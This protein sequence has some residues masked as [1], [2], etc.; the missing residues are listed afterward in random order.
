[1]DNRNEY[2]DLKK[3]WEVQSP[4]V[5]I[6]EQNDFANNNSVDVSVANNNAQIQ[7]EK[8]EVESP[9]S[10]LSPEVQEFLREHPE[11]HVSG[12]GDKEKE[13]YYRAHSRPATRE[14]FEDFIDRQ[15]R[16]A[17]YGRGTA[18]H[19]IFNP[20]D[21]QKTI[22]EIFTSPIY[23]WDSNSQEAISRAWYESV[24]GIPRE[25]MRDPNMLKY[26]QAEYAKGLGILELQYSSELVVDWFSNPYNLEVAHDDI[27]ALSALGRA[28]DDYA[29][30]FA[31]DR[32]G[33]LKD[34]FD[35]GWVKYYEGGANV[36]DMVAQQIED[37]IKANPGKYDDLTNSPYDASNP[38]M[39]YIVRT[40]KPLNLAPTYRERARVLRQA[41]DNSRPEPY[42]APSRRGFFGSLYGFVGDV[43]E[44]S[45]YTLSGIPM[46]FAL[47]FAGSLLGPLGFIGGNLL[48]SYFSAADEA[49]REQAEVYHQL[50]ADGMSTQ[51]AYQKTLN[52]VFYPNMLFLTGSNYFQNMFT[53]GAPIQPIGPGKIG[54]FKGFAKTL[55]FGKDDPLKPLSWGKRFWNF[56]LSS[57]MEG[58]EEIVQG[59]I[60]N[61]ALGQ[62][63]NWS[64]LGY[65][66]L[67][68]IA[69][70]MLFDAGGHVFRNTVG[71][72]VDYV[73]DKRAVRSFIKQTK[74]MVDLVDAA[75]ASETLKRSPE[76]I[77]DF[78]EYV[79]DG[80]TKISP[81]KTLTID[82]ET[83]N[84]VLGNE[85]QEVAET[86]GVKDDFN[87]ALQGKGS[88]EFQI[89]I[90]DLVSHP[91]IFDKIKNDLQIGDTRMSYNEAQAIKN[92]FGDRLA[93][94]TEEFKQSEK[95]IT[96][97]SKELEEITQKYVDRIDK[98]VGK[99]FVESNEKITHSHARALSLVITK[100]IKNEFDARKDN[101]PELTLQKVANEN[102]WNIVW[103]SI[104]PGQNIFDES[105]IFSAIPEIKSDKEANKGFWT[106]LKDNVVLKNVNNVA[107]NS[108]VSNVENVNDVNSNVGWGLRF[109]GNNDTFADNILLDWDSEILVQPEPVRNAMNSLI[110]VLKA[111]NYDTSELERAATGKDFYETLSGMMLAQI[112]SENG[113]VHG[114]YGTVERPEKAA[115]FLLDRA[116]VPGL[117]HTDNTNA[118]NFVIWNQTAIKDL[119]V[120]DK[121]KALRL[122]GQNDVYN[123]IAHDG[124]MNPQVRANTSANVPSNGALDDFDKILGKTG[125]KNVESYRQTAYTGT[126]FD[127]VIKRFLL[128][129][130]GTGQG[131]QSFGWG[132]YSSENPDVAETY[133]TE[134]L[135]KGSD[136]VPFILKMKNGR[137]Y[138]SI[139]I[140]K[141]CDSNEVRSDVIRIDV[142]N[143][144][145][146][147]GEFISNDSADKDKRFSD[148]S[149]YNTIVDYL[150]NTA[151]I[152]RNEVVHFLDN[153]F[154]DF[155]KYYDD[156][157]VYNDYFAHGVR[158]RED[159]FKY[160][161]NFYSFERS[162]PDEKISRVRKSRDE[163]IEDCKRDGLINI[164]FNPIL[165]E[166]DYKRL[167]DLISFS[168]VGKKIDGYNVGRFRYLFGLLNDYYEAYGKLPSK[169]ELREYA[170]KNRKD[171]YFNTVT[172][173]TELF[174]I[175]DDID[176]ISSTRP[177]E[178]SIYKLKIPENEVLLDWDANIAD[179]PEKVKEVIGIITR[180]L[181]ATLGNSNEIGAKGHIYELEHA[182]TGEDFYRALQIIMQVYFIN[183]NGIIH[184]KFGRVDRGDQA[185]SLL[186]DRLGIPG[187]RYFDGYSRLKQ[188]G[189]HNF[190]IWNEDAI[191]ILGVEG[192]AFYRIVEERGFDK[193]KELEKVRKKYEGTDK[194]LKAPNGK[195][196]N[197]SEELWLLVRTPNFIRWFGDFENDSE[198]ASKVVDENGE[199]LVV[200]FGDYSGIGSRFD[201]YYSPYIDSV[202]LNIRNPYIVEL[203]TGNF[204]YRLDSITKI[205]ETW[206]NSSKYD[207]AIVD[208]VLDYGTFQEKY[209]EYLL[210]N[211]EDIKSVNNIGTFDLNNREYL[212]QE[213][214]N[215]QNDSQAEERQLITK[216]DSVFDD[217]QTIVRLFEYA[218][219]STLIHELGHI[220]FNNRRILA[221]LPD[222]A[223]YVKRD[224]ATLTK[225][226]NIEDLD[227]DLIYA[228]DE[229]V[230][231]FSPEQ[232]AKY[233]AEK[234][235]WRT[236]HEKFAAS[237]EKYC[238]E[239]SAPSNALA[240]AFR[241]FRDWLLGIYKAI[242]NVIY[243][244][245]DGQAHIFTISKEVREVMDRMLASEDEI[246]NDRTIRQGYD[247]ARSFREGVGAKIAFG[248][249][250]VDS[251][252]L[253]RY[254]YLL[255][256]E[257]DVAKLKMFQKLM[258]ERKGFQS[259][260]LPDI[261]INLSAEKD[262]AR[263]P[264]L[265]LGDSYEQAVFQGSPFQGLIDRYN[266]KFIGTGEGT[267]A[268]GWGFYFAENRATGEFY[269]KIG[270]PFSNLFDYNIAVKYKNGTV[271]DSEQVGLREL[272]DDILNKNA[273]FKFAKA[274]AKIINS[275]QEFSLDKFRNYLR[276]RISVMEDLL[277]G[278]ADL[279]QTN[280]V[281]RKIETDKKKIASAKKTLEYLETIESITRT[282]KRDEV[283]EPRDKGSVYQL[284]VPE[285][286]VLLNYDAAI[287]EQPEYV[288]ERLSEIIANLKEKGIATSGHTYVRKFGEM[289]YDLEQVKT[290]KEFYHTLEAIMDSYMMTHVVEDTKFGAVPASDMA[291]SL[292]LNEVGIPGLRFFDKGSR[293]LENREDVGTHNFVIWN[294]DVIKILGFEGDA[295][296]Y[297]NELKEP[298]HDLDLVLGESFNQTAYHGTSLDKF[299]SRFSLKFIG[300]GE[301]YQSFGWGMY[302]GERKD[303]VE[304]Y[305]T[306]GLSK[307]FDEKT[308][309][310]FS[311][312]TSYIDN[313]QYQIDGYRYI[314]DK[315]NVDFSSVSSFF[316]GMK[317]RMK[318][319]GW[320]QV[321]AEKDIINDYEKKITRFKDIVDN[322]SS[323]KFDYFVP[324][325]AE[326][327]KLLDSNV[328]TLDEV[329]KVSKF[330]TD[331]KI[332]KENP[333]RLI[334]SIY[335][336]DVPENDVLLDYDAE[337]S[338]QPEKV[339]Q[340]M[341]Q[342]VSYLKSK[343]VPTS[344]NG[345]VGSFAYSFGDK[346]HD[347]E[348]VKTGAEFYHTL[349]MIMND[350][351][352]KRK[353]S[354][355][356]YGV[357][358]KADMAASLLFDKFGIPGLR[359]FDR[360]SRVQQQGTHNFVI[361]NED[362]V[363]I[364]G[365]EGDAKRYYKEFVKEKLAARL[366][367]AKQNLAK[368][369]NSENKASGDFYFSNDK[370]GESYA[371]LQLTGTGFQGLIDRF[372]LS[373]IGSG[374]GTKW[375][376]WGLYFAENSIVGTTYRTFGLPLGKRGGVHFS[377][378]FGDGNVVEFDKYK[379]RPEL[380]LSYKD[381]AS[382]Y[383][384]AFLAR[385]YNS[386]RKITSEKLLD[387]AKVEFIKELAKFG[388]GLKKAEVENA[389]DDIA[390][391][392]KTIS[393]YQ[394]ILDFLNRPDL[395]FTINEPVDN[396]IG[397]IYYAELP[398]ND[399]L[400]DYDA[401][402]SKQP[403]KVKQAML[404]MI[405]MLHENNIDTT[406]DGTIKVHKLGYITGSLEEAKTGK[407]FYH[408][409]ET[410]MWRTINAGIEVGTTTNNVGVITKADQAAS[411]FFDNFGIPGLRFYDGGSRYRPD[412]AKYGTRNFV[413][414]NEDAIKIVDVE[415]D[416]KDI[417]SQ[418]KKTTEKAKITD[419]ESLLQ[420]NRDVQS[421]FHN[422]MLDFQKEVGGR[423]VERKGDGLKS[424][425]RITEKLAPYVAKYGSKVDYSKVEDVLAA[426]LIFDNERE[427][428]DAVEKIKLKDVVKKVRNRWDFP[429][430]G[431]YR[432]YLFHVQLS[433]GVIAELQLHHK[434]LFEVK[435]DIGHKLYEFIRS[436][437]NK[438]EMREYVD[439]VAQFSRDLY[440]AGYDGIYA[441]A[442]AISKANLSEIGDAVSKSRS[443]SES[444]T[445]VKDLSELIKK[446]LSANQRL[447]LS[448]GTSA[449][450]A[451]SPLSKYINNSNTSLKN[452]NSNLSGKAGSVN[453]S[454]SQTGY[455]LDW[456]EKL[457]EQPEE[458]KESLRKVVEF[459]INLELDSPDSRLRKS[460]FDNIFKTPEIE[461][462]LISEVLSEFGLENNPN[463]SDKERADIIKGLMDGT[464]IENNKA[465]NRAIAK[466][467]REIISSV[468]DLLKAKTG[469]E[470][471]T[472]LESLME[473]YLKYDKKYGEDITGSVA[474]S[475]LL[476]NAGI[477]GLRSFDKNNGN[478]HVY[479]ILNN[480]ALNILGNT[481]KKVNNAGTDLYNELSNV[482][483]N[484]FT[485]GSFSSESY[486][487]IVYRGAFELERKR[488]NLKFYDPKNNESSLAW[489]L[490]F[491]ESLADAEN[492]SRP[493]KAFE[494]GKHLKRGNEIILKLFSGIE[495]VKLKDGTSLNRYA[496]EREID[497]L[498]A[499][500]SKKSRVKREFAENILRVLSYHMKAGVTYDNSDLLT[501]VDKLTMPII[502][503]LWL[504]KTM[505][506]ADKLWNSG[507][508]KIEKNE[509]FNELG[510]KNIFTKFFTLY[511][512]DFSDE[513][514][515]DPFTGFIR[516]FY[517]GKAD[518]YNKKY[519]ELF[520][521]KYIKGLSEIDG[522]IAL[523]YIKERE[524]LMKQRAAILR[525][526]NLF[527]ELT[528]TPDSER[529][530][531]NVYKSNIP[532]R[533]VLLDFN[534][535]ISEQPVVVKNAINHIKRVFDYLGLTSEQLERAETGG[536]F[537]VALEN[538]MRNYI[539]DNGFFEHGRFGEITNAK[540]ATSLILDA[541]GVPGMRYLN[542][543]SATNSRNVHDFVIWNDG[544][545]ENLEVNGQFEELLKTEKEEKKFYLSD[546]WKKADASKL[547]KQVKLIDKV[548]SSGSKMPVS[549][550]NNVS[551]PVNRNTLLDEVNQ[552]NNANDFHF[553]SRLQNI[554]LKDTTNLEKLVPGKGYQ[555]VFSSVSEFNS[556]A[557][558]LAKRANVNVETVNNAFRILASRT[559]KHVRLNDDGVRYGN[560][561]NGRYTFKGVELDYFAPLWKEIVDELS[562]S[563][564]WRDKN[565]ASTESEKFLVENRKK[566]NTLSEY[567]SDC[568][569]SID[570]RKV[571]EEGLSFAEFAHGVEKPLVSRLGSWEFHR[572]LGLSGKNSLLNKYADKYN[573]ENAAYV[574]PQGKK[575]VEKI[576]RVSKLENDFKKVT[577]QLDS[578]IL[579][580]NEALTTVPLN[581]ISQSGIETETYSQTAYNV[582]NSP[583]LV[584]EYMSKT[585]NNK[586]TRRFGWGVPFSWNDNVVELR[587]KL[588]MPLYDTVSVNFG[589]GKVSTGNSVSSNEFTRTITE[590]FGDEIGEY[591]S[592]I[593]ITLANSKDLTFRKL[594]TRSIMSFLSDIMKYQ[595]ELSNKPY[596]PSARFIMNNRLEL[597]KKR[598]EFLNSVEDITLERLGTGGV[599]DISENDVLIDS[600]AKISEQPEKVQRAM[601]AIKTWL[602]DK[603]F[604]IKMLENARTG[605]EF[606]R[607]LVSI[608]NNYLVSSGR[609]VLD[610]R[611]YGEMTRPD[612]VASVL[613]DRLGVRGL[614]YADNDSEGTNN[615]V[616]WNEDEIKLLTFKGREMSGLEDIG[617]GSG[618][619]YNQ[620]SIKEDTQNFLR[621]DDKSLNAQE[622]LD[623]VRNKYFGTN[624]WLK[625]PNGQQSRLNE[626]QWL[627]VRT[628]NFKRWFGDWE[629]DPANASKA[630]D[631][632]G[633]PLVVYHARTKTQGTI[634]FFKTGKDGGRGRTTGTGAWFAE[635]RRNAEYISKE[636]LDLNRFVANTVDWAKKNLRSFTDDG[637]YSVEDILEG[638]RQGRFKGGEAEAKRIAGSFERSKKILDLQPEMIAIVKS[639]DTPEFDV[640]N[641]D[642][643]N[644]QPLDITGKQYPGY[645]RERIEE[646]KDF[647]NVSLKYDAIDR[648]NYRLY[649]VFVNARNPYIYDAH[650]NEWDN[651]AGE[652]EESKRKYKTDELVKEVRAGK[653]D[654]EN[655]QKIPYDSVIIR[656]VIDGAKIDNDKE[657][658]DDY[659]IFI[660]TNIKS[661]TRNNGEFGLGTNNI[662]KQTAYGNNN[663][664]LR[665]DVSVMFKSQKSPELSQSSKSSD[666]SLLNVREQLEA[667]HKK[668]YG[669]NQWLKAPNGKQSN[670]TE[671]QWLQVRTPNFKR[672]FGDW[673][674][675][676]K[677]ASK[678][679]DVNG[680]PLVVYHGTTVPNIKVFQRG[681]KGWLGP[682]I[683]FTPYKAYAEDYTKRGDNGLVM[684]L[685]LNIRNPVIVKTTNP[686]MELLTM[687]YGDRA[688][689]VF[690]YRY[691]KIRAREVDNF[692]RKMNAGEIKGAVDQNL[693]RVVKRYI[694]SDEELQEIFSRG[695]YDG[696]Y[697]FDPEELAELKAKP[698]YNGIDYYGTEWAVLTSKRVKSI[699]NNGFFRLKTGNIYSQTAYENSNK[700]TGKELLEQEL[701]RYFG[702][703]IMLSDSYDIGAK[704]QLEAV[705]KKYEGT[706][707]W[708]KAPNGKD[709]LL[710]RKQWLQVRTENFKKWFGDWEN[711]PEHASKALDENG[712]PLVVYHFT[713]AEGFSV[714]KTEGRGRTKGTGAFFNSNPL[715]A[716]TYARKNGTK[717]AV[718]LNIRNPYVYDA[719]RKNWNA[720]E[721]PEKTTDKFTIAVWNGKYGKGYDGVIFKNI[722]DFGGKSVSLLREVK[723]LNLG[724]DYV[725]PNSRQIKSAT[726]NNGVFGLNTDNIYRQTAYENENKK[727]RNEILEQ[728]LSKYFKRTI[729]L[730]ND[731][732]LNAQ[733]QLEAVRKK[734]EGTDQWL[735]APNGKKSNL[736]EKQWLQVRTPNFKRW[737]GDWENTP[738][739]ASKVLDENGEPLV[740]YHGTYSDE[741]DTFSYDYI[742]KGSNDYGWLGYGFYFTSKRGLTGFYGPNVMELFLNL[743][744]PFKNDAA[745][746][747]EPYKNILSMF[748][749]KKQVPLRAALGYGYSKERSMA[750]SEALQKDGYDG[751]IGD[752]VISLEYVA[753]L[754]PQ[755]KSA[756]KNNGDFSDNPN[757]FRQLGGIKAAKRQDSA[758]GVT[759]RMD[760]LEIAKRMK[761]SF[762]S[763][764]EIWIRTGW[765]CA[766]DNGWRYEIYDGQFK[767][768]GF[769]TKEQAKIVQEKKKYDKELFEF[770]N[771]PVVSSIDENSDPS[772]LFKYANEI[773]NFKYRGKRLDKKFGNLNKLYHYYKN[774]SLYVAYPELKD[775]K[776][777][778]APA[779]K[780]GFDDYTYAF[781][782]YANNAIVIR[783]DMSNEE[784][785]FALVHE[786]QHVI[787]YIEGFATGGSAEMFEEDYYNDLKAAK[788]TTA[789]LEELDK[790]IG[791]M[792]YLLDWSKFE[793]VGVKGL[794]EMIRYIDNA[795]FNSEYAEEYRQLLAEQKRLA[796]AFSDKYK[797]AEN[798]GEVYERLGGEV[799]ARNVQNRLNLS[800][801]ERRNMSP[802]KT[803]DTL[804]WINIDENGDQFS[805]RNLFGSREEMESEVTKALHSQEKINRLA[806]E[807]EILRTQITGVPRFNADEY[808]EAMAKNALPIARNIIREIMRKKPIS[809]LELK[810]YF[811]AERHANYQSMQAIQDKNYVDALR[812]KQ[813]ELVNHALAIAAMEIIEKNK[814]NNNNK[815]AVN[816]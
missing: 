159:L 243:V 430:A 534:A 4:F 269:R 282:G 575:L 308:T 773:E 654:N 417:Y 541:A 467:K 220:F 116:G 151:N 71:R 14:E 206:D 578:I 221:S 504:N 423:L 462:R 786:I 710:T 659:V 812:W 272:V 265:I 364:L 615:F 255:K 229:E 590:R 357:I 275:G 412:R 401:E 625:A 398:E 313:S 721:A 250:S 130:I 237:F 639:L 262:K 695:K 309:Y 560:I 727:T 429:N 624:Q 380:G 478:S 31:P 630:V 242:R 352:K 437:K 454:Y 434:D 771:D 328:K 636:R 40:D 302:F 326:A 404:E 720:L 88:T 132:L 631:K 63:N 618:E 118:N 452:D 192:D 263:K 82:A 383:L 38:A 441:H 207:A 711:D 216:G 758:E 367:R 457:S 55:L 212:A 481:Y 734:Y 451:S 778:I 627:Q 445:W 580:R 563:I 77:K 565:S 646:A 150:A 489:G 170:N 640:K 808:V 420:A 567:L 726:S 586:N 332:E 741:F 736:T 10:S 226:L 723:V 794:D 799:D 648:E 67:I 223:D 117:R 471:C 453:E 160:L 288:K 746:K 540:M 329:L 22:H 656:N 2:E 653:F 102:R 761:N 260:P 343:G 632:N 767:K 205:Q 268:F 33:D 155:Y 491:T 336:V 358:T 148:N 387:K 463:V 492:S 479:E 592:E 106:G 689:S 774:D 161:R 301:G 233:V 768:D 361:W 415:G 395:N 97:E 140:L 566:L 218:D 273:P 713:N 166:N 776:I 240:E 499:K 372:K 197:L 432:D 719:K 676:P 754:P 296:K 198:H 651:L 208:G 498:L 61:R 459:V 320:S 213:T 201:L 757:I 447:G 35:T 474:A 271:I 27:K 57:G 609:A 293:Y 411:L 125:N 508:L 185:A 3:K 403:K 707:K 211:P 126:G 90:A 112:N 722:Y 298:R 379:L 551:A 153:I 42:L 21:R 46:N 664:N 227:F 750:F 172:D 143:G 392:K 385:E 266:L 667:V 174:S 256:H 542:V 123:Q 455:V 267:R 289:D 674:N 232:K 691:E 770:L 532:E 110:N 468:M 64:E 546:F 377:A 292:L 585:G 204:K 679:L 93:T 756:T 668:Y 561:L 231:N 813:K 145:S 593:V 514:F 98:V 280:Y 683:Y 431:G 649:P 107:D 183:K 620:V 783:D 787:Q 616:I 195:D 745:G 105:P 699:G 323:E 777:E 346:L 300:T 422:L 622:Q 502:D 306:A 96:A 814:A 662:Y 634:S 215:N 147:L 338:Q 685:Y 569:K 790:K 660:D 95:N 464:G 75:R 545:I 353:V 641:F 810:R 661:A 202:F 443:A 139:D 20:Q 165:T 187:L 779:E 795:R 144:M 669:T 365:F 645:S 254:E 56:A 529:A 297:Y 523:K 179:Q 319:F 50:V 348:Q 800:P 287:S 355:K 410:I 547:D 312:G 69:N 264:D 200:K 32:E 142:N 444:E 469:G 362:V 553:I 51:E 281:V 182:R 167:F 284:D 506:I 337:I 613:L 8:N 568:I 238:M 495:S 225:W 310:Y 472:K 728:E 363:K 413:I 133:R 103:R 742:G 594:K 500:V 286:D 652:P 801:E 784:T 128:S 573:N 519:S 360:D 598:L 186:F 628:D 684:E 599:Y 582:S 368:K 548:K 505:P 570:K 89:N 427:L 621:V 36:A 278:Q 637:Y 65:E 376:G 217:A 330:V 703:P 577:K 1:M 614:R 539:V 526:V 94:L 482:K 12:Q 496:S 285:N 311:D 340:A 175:I 189:T 552:E 127:G 555:P 339:K 18:I 259:L 370:S 149:N 171:N 421:E 765:W 544:L 347:L 394:K 157:D 574:T 446:T 537:Y 104:I 605:K 635:S 486:N 696:I 572:L 602:K 521:K 782:N 687:L 512:N 435:E 76:T 59:I 247:I 798:P 193:N 26:A 807:A 612:M 419:V 775:V 596:T 236:A 460:V 591:F 595:K 131:S 697:W 196:T 109:T 257:S 176:D 19:N 224:W 426:S 559:K 136:E 91:E 295:E 724:D 772:L 442:S 531:S 650:G 141:F 181:K 239:G 138:N 712:E 760:N 299:I 87:N 101:N 619:R 766:P 78:V 749:Y 744:N 629:N 517:S 789:R 657:V 743:R 607:S 137:K 402:I 484:A 317:L 507:K 579:S 235:R 608:F 180:C 85:A 341:E 557:K 737:F 258:G 359:Y 318:G 248:R 354:D 92:K 156:A 122:S 611:K 535:E 53:W 209:R 249:D 643:K 43:V 335:K 135:P 108:D 73:H 173:H 511:V 673:E 409:L 753:F 655:K 576:E 375:Y 705:R 780:Y 623:T 390:Y 234:A 279:K 562:K 604:N 321:Q 49:Q 60:S 816:F 440:Q 536:D 665:A 45:P 356:R 638:G 373:F 589:N 81:D 163:F 688:E 701:S 277:S 738:Q 369:N 785:A 408:M 349:E 513:V 752:G 763:D 222:V 476:E 571:V 666:D 84:K 670:L 74:A 276:G 554:T 428:L 797:G 475:L 686:M 700:K 290:G 28:I 261:D 764:Y 152:P 597:A 400:L 815:E 433:N 25:S 350:C 158:T 747:L 316:H 333:N 52:E 488:F 448:S 418:I 461:Q 583:D 558:V 530:K 344:W 178:G 58:V 244:D 406:F 755:I 715:V 324:D 803:A 44:G 480:K 291:A 113:L 399:E 13:D 725:I 439:Q 391:F 680:E 68:G 520:H 610:N 307:R 796:T 274:L 405:A 682:A 698:D 671:K 549:V 72:A 327:Q 788:E 37:D 371:Q 735:K 748:D 393:D 556:L 490:R 483:N 450:N 252:T 581:T 647:L 47:N 791:L 253:K 477:S 416:A 732:G 230:D 603:K 246:E 731:K 584:E 111:N 806:L 510:I 48:S 550:P 693:D 658:T 124:S 162:V 54:W 305:R 188:E 228:S 345:Y 80:E 714:F 473:K 811:N 397:S 781:Y 709:T 322:P 681:V 374:E 708:L 528:V 588:G 717:Y 203:L 407:E 199:P 533:D 251:E 303:V 342:I 524:I 769:F 501:I 270:L 642:M 739:K 466:N 694:I 120:T 5:K 168:Y 663:K 762:K 325:V 214:A 62:E 527:D 675:N 134:G 672:W 456:S 525:V 381:F 702:K 24:T 644:F 304:T 351:L 86:L 366:E 15:S 425:E 692:N 119:G 164:A 129:Y 245:A 283:K 386:N 39:N 79:I 190:V 805:R 516:L 626:K 11:I 30:L 706:D 66:G 704:Q 494:N 7:P 449:A 458:V 121:S 382:K 587:R 83:F 6:P 730:S 314:A 617:L 41:A 809:E 100:M 802:N 378:N 515:V 465:F 436:N 388:N 9:V 470:F 34:R 424:R 793:S 384:L 678:V 718:F 716:S 154:N 487:Q 219:A 210:K 633:E 99:N 677:N 601:N 509:V 70:G 751:V 16:K 114:Y 493:K 690:K 194:W 389:T 334:G 414:W 485:G 564:K 740:V 733:E 543:F 600:D 518:E 396:L 115:S 438:P 191:K 503:D 184:E 169:E 315:L 522:G 497:N 331:F 17:Q 23:D 759:T 177:L 294:E 241:N 29:R 146:L 538:I 606:Y 792:D 804:D 729:R